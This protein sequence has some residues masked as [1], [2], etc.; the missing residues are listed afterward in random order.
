MITLRKGNI[1]NSS[2]QTLV[3]AV[4]C[5]GVMGK[6]IALVYQCRYPEMF[7]KYANFCKT[8]DITIGKLYLYKPIDQSE[9]WVLNFPTKLSWRNPSRMDYLRAGFEKFCLT[10]QQKQISSIAFPM[11][12]TENGGLNYTEVK[13]L[14]MDYLSKCENINIE[15]WEYDPSVPDDLFLAFRSNWLSH[16]ELIHDIIRSQSMGLKADKIKLISSVLESGNINSM[17]DLIK[18][19]NIGIKTMQKA[20]EIA[21]ILRQNHSIQETF[22]S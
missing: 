1:F 8:G 12:G 11:L 13:T 10:Y 4:N 7:E 15:I 16:Y 9:Q 17:I 20:F 19:K 2:C 21:K 5:E 6:G 22:F 3:N 18:T 14:M